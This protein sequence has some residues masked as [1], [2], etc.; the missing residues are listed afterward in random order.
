[1]T[2]RKDNIMSMKELVLRFVESK[3]TATFKE[4][5]R[6]VVDHNYGEGTYDKSIGRIP[7]YSSWNP[8]ETMISTKFRGYYCGRLYNGG[9]W[10]K[11]DLMCGDSYLVR[12][13][14]GM[15]QA[16]FDGPKVS[17]FVTYLENEDVEGYDYNY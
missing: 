4:I 5:Q 9:Y 11:G 3:G 13:S 10:P 6:F 17:R 12:V 15:Y 8:E 14:R 1:M 16:V 7:K 2:I